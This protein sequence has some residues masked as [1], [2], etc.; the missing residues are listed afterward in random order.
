ML[1]AEETRTYLVE[2]YWPGVDER[3]VATAVGRAQAAALQLRRQGN[4]IEFLGSILVHADETVFCL[5]SGREA[6]VRVA[7]ERAGV[8]FHRVLEALR[9]DGDQP[10]G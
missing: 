3:K 2:C 7:S 1:G 9:I 8:T 6:D 4:E 5:F 10:E